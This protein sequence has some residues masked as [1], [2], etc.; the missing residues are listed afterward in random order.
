MEYY[1]Y[2]IIFIFVLW[3]FL[4]LYVKITYKFWAYQPVFHHYNILYWIY[5]CGII[6]EDLP[7][8][9][10]YCNFINIITKQLDEYS[11]DDLKDI[12][13]LIQNNYHRT[14]IA[15]Y[16]PTI[17]NFSSYFTGHNSKIF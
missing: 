1:Y 3:I 9:N 16:Y 7:K 5:P 12:L 2:L 15:N 13:D 8:S 17:D 10:K 14:K 11:K 6:N 4:K